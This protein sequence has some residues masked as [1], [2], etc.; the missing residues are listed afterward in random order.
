MTTN[1]LNR[2]GES[3]GIN[4]KQTGKPGPCKKT[5]PTISDKPAGKL[6]ANVPDTIDMSPEGVKRRRSILKKQKA[7]RIKLEKLLSE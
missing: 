3:L 7:A 6:F 2:I 5:G 1:E 4:C